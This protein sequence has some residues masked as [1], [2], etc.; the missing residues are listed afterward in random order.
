MNSNESIDII[1]KTPTQEYGQVIHFI[2]QYIVEVKCSDRII[3]TCS[4]PRIIYRVESNLNQDLKLDLNDIVLV[5]TN[6]GT[7]L[8]KY[9]KTETEELYSRGFFEQE[10]DESPELSYYSRILKYFN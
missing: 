1:L 5:S 10:H 2:G 6:D 8:R 3:R 9:S 4:I 7:I